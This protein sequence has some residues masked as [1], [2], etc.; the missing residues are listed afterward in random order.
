MIISFFSSSSSSAHHIPL[1]SCCFSQALA[2]FFFIHGCFV[3]CFVLQTAVK[4]ETNSCRHALRKNNEQKN[5]NQ[6]CI[7]YDY[8]RV[9][10]DKIDGVPDSD[11]V[12]ASYVDVS[13]RAIIAVD[14]IVV[15]LVCQ[16]VNRF[17]HWRRWGDLMAFI[18]FIFH[19]RAVVHAAAAVVA[20]LDVDR[21]FWNQT[22]I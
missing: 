15:D 17:S 1:C 3:S 21:A 11:Y 12:N 20:V 13:I 18:R 7:P 22:L 5:Q 19:S 16:F 9:V 2:C 10:L 4:V 8:N 14:V 6:K